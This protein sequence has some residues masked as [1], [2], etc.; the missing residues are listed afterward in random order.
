MV[1]PHLVR[2]DTQRSSESGDMFL[3]RHVNS[4][5]NL[6]TWSCELIGGSSSQ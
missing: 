1:S 5:E 3:I 2:F 4:Q 6:L